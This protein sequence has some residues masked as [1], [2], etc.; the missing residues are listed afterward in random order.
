MHNTWRLTFSDIGRE[1]DIHFYHQKKGSHFINELKRMMGLCCFIFFLIHPFM[2]GDSYPH[3]PPPPQLLVVSHVAVMLLLLLF[4]TGRLTLIFAL[5]WLSVLCW[6][7][8][9]SCPSF[10]PP[11]PPLSLSVPSIVLVWPVTIYFT[12]FLIFILTSPPLPHLPP[13][14]PFSPSFF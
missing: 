9:T 11:C 5:P 10:P 8:F 12:L 1:G 4:T 6:L 13:L 14:L 3:S 2:C 7:L